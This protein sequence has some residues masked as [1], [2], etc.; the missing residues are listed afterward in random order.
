MHLFAKTA[1]LIGGALLVTVTAGQ[2][3]AA[4]RPGIDLRG[5]DV[6]S[7]V[8]ADDGSARLSGD[9]TGD[10]FDGSYTAVLAAVDGSLP[11]PGVC[12]PG[13]GTLDVTG[14]KEGKDALHPGIDLCHSGLEEV[15]ATKKHL[16]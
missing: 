12:E 13:T 8:P 7:F 4:P 9:V 2:A 10:P 5:A 3:E 6:G 15:E 1:A 16:L 11:D 14:T